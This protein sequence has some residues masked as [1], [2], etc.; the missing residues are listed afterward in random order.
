MHIII[1]HTQ[2]QYTCTYYED[3]SPLVRKLSWRVLH[4]PWL[5]CMQHTEFSRRVDIW[6]CLGFSGTCCALVKQILRTCHG[7][8]SVLSPLCLGRSI[9]REDSATITRVLSITA[10]N[11]RLYYLRYILAVERTV[12]FFLSHRRYPGHFYHFPPSYLWHTTVRYNNVIDI[13]GLLSS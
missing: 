13:Y 2:D 1:I 6:N 7:F 5:H 3:C 12:I 4:R 11:F 8:V 10:A 9:P